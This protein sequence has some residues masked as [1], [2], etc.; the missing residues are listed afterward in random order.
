MNCLKNKFT[1]D[2]YDN[3]DIESEA[4][5]IAAEGIFSYKEEKN[6]PLDKFL[7]IHLH[8]RLFNFKRD[9]FIRHET[10][11]KICK[12]NKQTCEK[13]EKRNSLNERKIKILKPK[14]NLENIELP[15]DDTDPYSKD[16]YQHLCSILEEAIPKELFEDYLRLKDGQSINSKKKNDIINIAY[17]LFPDGVI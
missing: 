15:A 11:C 3:E 6:V 9:N 1:F 16:H 14:S 17:S 5:L 4:F 10:N 12:K 13:C 2:I 8:N 7:F